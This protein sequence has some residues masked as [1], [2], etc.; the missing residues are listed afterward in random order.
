MANVF[1]FDVFFM[2]ENLGSSCAPIMTRSR[3]YWERLSRGLEESRV[4]M[5]IMTQWHCVVLV[6]AGR[7]I[8]LDSSELSS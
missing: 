1:G 5:P 3:R 8:S 2:M 6:M 4:G 7:L